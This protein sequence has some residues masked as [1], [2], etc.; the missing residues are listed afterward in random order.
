MT[1]TEML[2]R[3]AR[4]YPNSP[5]LIEITPSRNLRNVI[6]WKEF[7][8]NANRFANALIARG[9]K[10]GD[11]VI[12]LMMN[13]TKWLETYFGILKT[14]AMAAPLNFRFIGRQIKYCGD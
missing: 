10:K 13:S 1:I 3:N 9:V 7:E 14:G 2:D 6:T 5:A 4:L 12:Q 11:V 8:N